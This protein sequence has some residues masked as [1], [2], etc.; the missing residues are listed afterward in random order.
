MPPSA[1]LF[2]HAV[3]LRI[4]SSFYSEIRKNT[5][6]AAVVA[7][8]LCVLV[9]AAPRR[10]LYDLVGGERVPAADEDV[11][12]QHLRGRRNREGTGRHQVTSDISFILTRVS[13]TEDGSEEEIQVMREWDRINSAAVQCLVPVAVMQPSQRPIPE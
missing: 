7:L 13:T 9:S 6:G 2:A 12:L 4:L 10:L 1:V 5:L 8:I 11:F 3:F